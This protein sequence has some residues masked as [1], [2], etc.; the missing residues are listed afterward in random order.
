MLS[1]GVNSGFF[2]PQKVLNLLI[3]YGA[4]HALS[5]LILP[6]LRR[7]CRDHQTGGETEIRHTDHIY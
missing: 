7:S 6:T 1:C 3:A 2:F 5:H 4:W